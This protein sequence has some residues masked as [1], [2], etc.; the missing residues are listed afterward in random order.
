MTDGGS[1]EPNSF[2]KTTTVG[3]TETIHA[4]A[5][6]TGPSEARAATS[7]IRPPVTPHTEARR[8]E[9]GEVLK[10]TRGERTAYV[11]PA[12]ADATNPYLLL[13]VTETGDR[14][15]DPIGLSTDE[16]AKRLGP[17]AETIDVDTVPVRPP[18]KAVTGGEG[19]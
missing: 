10:L 1:D 13:E 15:G 18:A 9:A 8:L 6:D 14:R 11:W 19:E 17:D 2:G 12:S 4:D 16:S 5:A 7:A 3:A